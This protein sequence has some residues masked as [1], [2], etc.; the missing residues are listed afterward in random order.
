[1][2]VRRL[3]FTF[4]TLLL[5]SGALGQQT[6]SDDISVRMGQ[7]VGSGGCRD[8]YPITFVFGCKDTSRCF[9]VFT[10]STNC[11]GKTFFYSNFTGQ[12]CPFLAELRDPANRANL[13]ALAATANVLVPDCK[14][15]FMPVKAL[16]ESKQGG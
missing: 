16:L 1:M 2:T 10:L 4:C 7:C 8:V 9:Q 3:I 13:L 12:T 11:C 14:G 15:V 5:S 6:C